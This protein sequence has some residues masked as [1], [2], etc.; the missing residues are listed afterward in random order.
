VFKKNASEG[1]ELYNK[2]IRYRK[3]SFASIKLD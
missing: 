1:E 3:K 2:A